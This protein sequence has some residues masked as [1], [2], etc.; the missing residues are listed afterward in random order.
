MYPIV[1][2]WDIR[3]MKN[4]LYNHC[5]DNFVN[6]VKYKEKK[7]LYQQ[8]NGIKIY[9]Y[10]NIDTTKSFNDLKSSDFDLIRYIR[11]RY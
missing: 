2:Y 6:N 3:M 10:L 5:V 8:N 1:Q 7:I 11:I 9:D 4:S